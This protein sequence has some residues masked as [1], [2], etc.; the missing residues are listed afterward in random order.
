MGDLSLFQTL[1]RKI[2]IMD[3]KILR[4]AAELKNLLSVRAS[5]ISVAAL[6]LSETTSIVLCLDIAGMLLSYPV[7]KAEAAKLS[8]LKKTGYQV[9]LKTLESVLDLNTKTSMRDLAVQFGCLPVLESA[10]NVLARYER[11]Q[12]CDVDSNSSLFQT[13]ALLCVCKREK[14]RIEQG[15][16]REVAGVKR[17]TMD[18][19]IAQMDKVA[20]KLQEEGAKKK[21]IKRKKRTLMDDIEKAVNESPSEA[22]PAKQAKIEK[23]IDYYKNVNFEEWKRKLLEKASLDTNDCKA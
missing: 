6:R 2:G 1:G 20:D 11:E 17:S 23:D 12:C 16:L 9:A 19:L 4:K 14:V 10:A 8:G 5:S 21:S 13:A 18:R 7:D 15:R 22:I 3:R